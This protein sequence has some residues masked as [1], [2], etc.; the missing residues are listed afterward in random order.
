[1]AD[2][3]R[4]IQALILPNGKKVIFDLRRR[5]TEVYDLGADPGEIDN[6]AD[7]P[8]HEITSAI[9]TAGYFFDVHTL[10][11]AGWEPPWRKF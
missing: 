8:S 3:G 5:T 1:V 4:R 6:L 11:R 9:A 7:D 2:A 10:K